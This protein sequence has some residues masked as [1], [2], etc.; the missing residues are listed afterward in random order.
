MTACF[1]VIFTSTRT[2]GDNGYADAAERMA[3][4][5]SE[6]PGFLGVESVRGADGVGITVSYWQSEAAILAWRQHPEHRLIQVRGRSQWYSSFQTRV[7]KV[8]REYR[9]SL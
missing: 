9:F 5:V 2:D 8:E 7:C 3:E 4:L 6:Q 1:A